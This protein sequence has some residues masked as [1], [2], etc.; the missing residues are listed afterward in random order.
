MSPNAD[1]MDKYMNI[2]KECAAKEGASDADIQ[3]A[4]S[5]KMPTTKSGKCLA[6][7]VGEQMKVI[8]ANKIDVPAVM[9]MVKN[10]FGDDAETLKTAGE[11]VTP[12]QGVT[13]GDRC[14]AVGKIME[15]T[16]KGIKAHGIEL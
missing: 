9:D 7:C 14:E 10:A 4:M 2:A 11:I 3:S 16:D 12:C 1:A 13:D 8:Q 5:F 6:A 15:C